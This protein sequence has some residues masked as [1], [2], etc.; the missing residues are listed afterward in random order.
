MSATAGNSQ[1]RLPKPALL[2]PPS[3]F[4]PCCPLLPLCSPPGILCILPM[5]CNASLQ[6]RQAGSSVFLLHRSAAGLLRECA[7]GEKRQRERIC[8]ACVYACARV[9]IS[10]LALCC[11]GNAGHMAQAASRP[12]TARVV[13]QEASFSQ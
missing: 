11:H 1:L 13:L 4:F 7:W 10:L 12:S 3:V 6:Q 5:L 2:Y 8:F 9:C